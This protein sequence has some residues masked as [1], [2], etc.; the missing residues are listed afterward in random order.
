MQ[1]SEYDT[2]WCSMSWYDMVHDFVSDVISDMI[3][4][5]IYHIW[6]KLWS[7]LIKDTWYMIYGYEIGWDDMIWYGMRLHD[8]IYRIWC[9]MIYDMICD[10]T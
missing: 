1:W 8:A 2:Q 10:V 9:E 5:K 7:A 6:C 3:C 4:Y